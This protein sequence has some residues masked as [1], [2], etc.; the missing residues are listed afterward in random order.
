MKKTTYLKTLLVALCLYAGVN[1]AWADDVVVPTPKYFNDFSS[2]TYLTQV[3]S[4]EFVKDSDDRFGKI[5]HNN[6]SKNKTARTNYLKLPADVL[7]HSGSTNE[8]SI[9]FWVNVKDA[10]SDYFHCPVF[11]A[12]ATS[13]PGSNNGSPMFRASAKG[14]MQLNNGDGKWTDFTKEENDDEGKKTSGNTE[15]TVYLD[16]ANWHYYTITLTS[17]NGIIYVDG[18][19][20]NSWT[21]K[22]DDITPAFFATAASGGYPVVCLGGNQSWDWNDWDASFGYDDIAIYDTALS[23]EQI[24]KIISNKLHYTVNAVDG[25]SKILKVLADANSSANSVSVT[26]P[27]YILDGTTLREAAATDSKYTKS[28]TLTS[29]KQTSTIAYTNSSVSNVY[30][31]AEGE[32][33]LTTYKTYEAQS[34]SMNKIAY[35]AN[36]TAFVKVTTLPAGT[37]TITA[38]YFCGNKT[39][40][41]NAYI[42][43]GSEVKWSQEYADGSAGNSEKT[44]DSFNLTQ[45]TAMYVAADGGN[46]TGFDWFYVSGTPSNT[47]VGEPDYSTDYLVEMS[48]KVTLS[49][50]QSWHYKFVNHNMGPTAGW[51]QNWVLPVYASDG[52]TKKIVIRSDNWEDVIWASTGFGW[53]TSSGNWYDNFVTEMNNATVDMTIN[54]SSTNVLTM[55]AKI[56]TSTDRT[57]TY[58]YNSSTAGVSLSDN[59]KIA[60]S[61][62]RSWLELMES[63]PTT[64]SKTIS[65]AGWATYCSPYALDFSSSIA[66]LD[67]A[68]IITGNSGASL[69]LSPITTTIP[70]NTGILLEGEGVVNIPVVASSTT[71]V[72]ANKLVGKTAEYALAAGGGYVL[73]ASPKVGFYKNTNAFTVGAN[74]AYLPVGFGTGYA[75]SFFSF[76][77]EETTS[78]NEL[79]TTNF[80]NNTNEVFDLQ[81]RRV[82]QPTKGLYIVNG[83]KVVIK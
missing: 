79:K 68:Y 66:N 10:S 32:D 29:S 17:T 41:H 4:G 74:T 53:T 39:G 44:S 28:F 24:N 46:V 82:A 40:T 59:I 26:Y 9:G 20:V 69:T 30:Y 48:D 80:T 1:Q 8:M 50:G 38:R 11:S 73:M 36:S 7:T 23:A 15:S 19:V 77:D 18:N 42:K 45:P 35:T 34:L 71:N 33:V 61:V 51:A 43:V 25:S 54:Y 83:K 76:D 64:V 37:W 47:I 14:V 49:P 75:R 55:T 31:Y 65:D 81:G 13:T 2:T 27:R 62:S 56:T 63:W 52:T 60:I 6:P 12:Y 70:A 3:G 72:D 22:S 57:L 67:G 58:T 78:V 5:Y 16:D 21:I